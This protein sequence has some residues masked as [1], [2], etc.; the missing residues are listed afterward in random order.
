MDGYLT[1]RRSELAAGMVA[2]AAVTSMLPAQEAV[3]RGSQAARSLAA[4]LATEVVAAQTPDS[5]SAMV[6]MVSATG[7]RAIEAMAVHAGVAAATSLGNAMRRS[8]QRRNTR[9]SDEEGA[10]ED[11]E[12]TE[13]DTG[14]T[15]RC[16]PRRRPRTTT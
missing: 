7:G 2:G 10:N 1:S 11:G 12:V 6:E 14:C 8:C 4:D 15:T 5:A 3:L 13:V 16:R 9:T